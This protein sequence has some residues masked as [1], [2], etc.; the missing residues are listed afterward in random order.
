MGRPLYHSLA[1]SLME[2]LLAQMLRLT[3]KAGGHQLIASLGT[4]QV[5][6]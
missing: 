1:Q 3:L 6:S 2:P 4:G 5:L